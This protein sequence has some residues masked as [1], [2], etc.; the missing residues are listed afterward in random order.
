MQFTR[1]V[2]TDY[3]VYTKVNLQHAA[4]LG[5]HQARCWDRGHLISNDSKSQLTDGLLCYVWLLVTYKIHVGMFARTVL[6]DYTINTKDNL[7]A[8]S[9]AHPDVLASQPPFLCA[10][11]A[12]V[13][14]CT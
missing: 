7:G 9:Q 10:C 13:L 12:C 11:V 4:P 6:M 3:L 8:L 14:W 5:A 1:T 2:I